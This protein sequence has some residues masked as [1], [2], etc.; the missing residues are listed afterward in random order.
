[1][2]PRWKIAPIETYFY[3]ERRFV[4]ALYWRRWYGWKRLAN[5]SSV[6]GAENAQ[7]ELAVLPKYL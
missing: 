2:K 3:H 4:C 5:F 1:M 7:A 6:K